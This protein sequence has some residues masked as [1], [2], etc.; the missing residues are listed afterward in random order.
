[1]GARDQYVLVEDFGWYLLI[2]ADVAKT[3]TTHGATVAT[4]F[5][6]IA[7]RVAQVVLLHYAICV[8]ELTVCVFVYMCV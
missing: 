3:K 7:V 5:L 1:M 8:L 6:D 2:L 4:Q